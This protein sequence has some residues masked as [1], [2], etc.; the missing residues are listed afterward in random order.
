MTSTTEVVRYQIFQAVD[1][2]T[3]DQ[4]LH[5]VLALVQRY[6]RP[7]AEEEVFA[8]R[9]PRMTLEQYRE[10]ALRS[11]ERV[12]NGEKFSVE[13]VEEKILGK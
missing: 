3:D 9:F 2:I 6:E 12:R 13:E 5:A 10:K 11:V 4:F 7:L 1:A 8:Q